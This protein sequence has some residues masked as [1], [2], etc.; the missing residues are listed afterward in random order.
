MELRQ[1]LIYI[2]LIS[3]FVV[4]LTGVGVQMALD[5]GVQTAFLNNS[6]VNDTRN[7]LTAEIVSLQATAENQSSVQEQSEPIVAVDLLLDSTPQSAQKYKAN[8][9]D[10]MTI[11]FQLIASVINAHPAILAIF[12]SIVLITFAT[13]I[14][15]FIKSGR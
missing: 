13:L 8:T 12:S 2:G 4:G 6:F 9:K 10:M 11:I 1:F 15:G 7:N 5:N 14:W 3:L